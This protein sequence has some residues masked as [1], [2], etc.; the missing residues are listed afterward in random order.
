MLDTCTPVAALARGGSRAQSH[1]GRQSQEATPSRWRCRSDLAES[2][3]AAGAPL[4]RC[5]KVAQPGRPGPP[6]APSHRR[7]R[8]QADFDSGWCWSA[9]PCSPCECTPEGASSGTTPHRKIWHPSREAVRFWPASQSFLL[10][11]QPSTPPAAPRGSL[12]SSS[13]K[14]S[15]RPPA[16]PRPG[17]PESIASRSA[18]HRSA[19]S[20]APRCTWSSRSGCKCVRQLPWEAKRCTTVLRVRKRSSSPWNISTRIFLMALHL[21]CEKRLTSVSMPARKFWDLPLDRVYGY[22]R[23]AQQ[24]RRQNATFQE[25]RLVCHSASSDPPPRGLR[26]QQKTPVILSNKRVFPPKAF[27]KLYK[28]KKLSTVD[29][30]KHFSTVESL[31]RPKLS[32]SN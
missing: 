28:D 22:R 16:S 27:Q 7:E 29:K 9:G 21:T 1:S 4:W 18:C 17:S 11:L 5:P 24:K 8:A 6:A 23:P 2:P 10:A 19:A 32:R 31:S 15:S 12:F 14:R 20:W 13:N 3:A 25:R 26:R 30:E